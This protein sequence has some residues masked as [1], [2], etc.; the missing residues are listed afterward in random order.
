MQNLLFEHPLNERTRTLLRISHLFEQFEYHL[1]ASSAWQS[2]GAIQALL[3]IASILSRAD[4]KSEMIKQLDQHARTLEAM[5]LNPDVDQRR[6]RSVL[7]DIATT[8]E[9]LHA[10]DGQLGNHLRKNEFLN[11]IAQRLPIPGGSF[12]FDLPQYHY[13]LHLPHETRARE[14]DGWRREIA[15]VQDAV[16]LLLGLLRNS[17]VPREMTASRGI[18]QKSLDPQRPVEMIQVSIEPTLGLFA[19]ISGSKH[20]FCVRFMKSQPRERPSATEQD[21]P[22]KLKT[23]VI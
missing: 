4:L 17:S 23:C 8:G 5:A 21:V 12:E 7:E 15:V 18:Y 20:R 10:V 19:E 3:E 6:L 2:R 1:A 11:S 16:E 14:L 13:W 9:R 22:F